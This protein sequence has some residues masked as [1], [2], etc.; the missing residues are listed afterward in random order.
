MIVRPLFLAASSLLLG[1]CNGGQVQQEGPLVELPRELS[2]SERKLADSSVEFGLALLREVRARSKDPNVVLSPLSASTALALALN[3]ARGETFDDLRRGLA[4]PAGTLEDLNAA[5]AG[6][7]GLLTG[8][9]RGIE[10][11]VANALFPERSFSLRPDYLERTRSSFEAETQPLDFSDPGAVD[12][13]NEWV[14]RR[15]ANRIQR[16]LQR[17]APEEVLFLVNAVHF[18]GAWQDAFDPD[19]THPQPFRRADGSEVSVPMMSRRQGPV[20]AFRDAHAHVL[21]LPYGRGAFTMV[22]VLPHEE[23]TL[24]DLLG[25]LDAATWARWMAGLSRTDLTVDVPRLRIEFGTVLTDPLKSLGMGRAFEAG[26]ADFSGLSEVGERNRLYISRVEQKAF[27]EVDER[28]T[29]AAA[30]TTVAIGLVSL[31]PGF[32]ADRPFLI[33]IRERFSGAL[34]FVGA[35]GDPSRS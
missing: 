28:G 26:R 8:L 33:A 25:E 19:R 20:S 6:L 32:R 14:A 17:I 5:Y 15:T 35:I 29:T 16:V 34:L 9:D 21:E 22:W 2:A 11:R 12:T 27:L 3:G 30:A 1:G 4:L 13:V 18:H 7:T 24:D 31:P 23:R 10:L